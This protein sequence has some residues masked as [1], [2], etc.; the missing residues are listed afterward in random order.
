MK[1][2]IGSVTMMLALLISGVAA[3]FSVVGL[4]A[5]FPA[6]AGAVILMGC[7][8]EA[9]KLSSAGWLHSNWTNPKASALHR[10]YMVAAVGAL[11]LITSLGIY[12]FLAK[13]HLEEQT[14][15]APVELQIGQKQAQIVQ[16]NA[17]VVRLTAQ[18]TQITGAVTAAIT[19]DATKGLRTRGHLSG[20][21]KDIQSKIDADNAQLN[22]LTTD[23]VPLKLQVNEVETK[24]GPIKY[25]GEAIG[26]KDTEGAVRIVIMILMFAFDPLAVVMVLSGAI[27]I[28][29]G[30]HERRERVKEAAEVVSIPAE[31]SMPVVDTISKPAETEI[32]EPEP[33][34]PE[35][36]LEPEPEP[37]IEAKPPMVEHAVRLGRRGFR[38]AP[39]LGWSEDEVDPQNPGNLLVELEPELSTPAPEAETVMTDKE[40]LLD[41][42][43]RKP[44]LLQNIVEAI[45]DDAEEKAAASTAEPVTPSW[46]DSGPAK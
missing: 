42:L 39:R 1:I 38:P 25:L 18:Q 45:R 4:A 43:E 21:S 34:T 29:D 26:L 37:E 2:I 20:E 7:A 12:G 8:L 11:M 24:L 28:G 6:T 9:G 30:L 40:R 44:E 3:Y 36:E 27:S 35:I 32:V 17:D 5:I 16:I 15:L 10:G 41:I 22:K 33:E 13:G 23:L 14:P 46:L 19:A 31:V